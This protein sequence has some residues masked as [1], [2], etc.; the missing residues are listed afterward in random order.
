MKHVFDGLKLLG[1]AFCVFTAVLNAYAED[2]DLAA[3]FQERNVVGTLVIS[4]LDENTIYIHNLPR[5]EERF[6][7]A[8]TFKIP[9]TLIALEEGVV[10]NEKEV[11]AW[12]GQD[13]GWKEWNKDQSLET[14]FPLSCV[15]F[16]QE[17]AK[18]IGNER[19]IQHLQRIH[20]GNQQTGA[21]VTTFWL[22]G[23]LRI[24][25]LEQIEFL[26]K[27]HAEELPYTPSHIALL[28]QLMIV[29]E[30]LDY[31]IRAKT[32]WTSRVTPQIGW[33]VGYVETKGTVWFFA[34][35]LEI[36]KKGDEKFRQEI[37]MEALRVKG[38]L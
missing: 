19:Y 4:S 27:V 12:D 9:N 6:L 38:I 22:E 30:T 7:P 8:S 10:A 3:L 20:Y 1:I 25:A 36:A 13:K 2:A 32:G 17:L 21:E 24:S 33:Y 34:V 23:D 14:A 31:V 15:W 18:R 28:K 11:I 37:I 5:A 29:E 16:Y 35:N 26:K